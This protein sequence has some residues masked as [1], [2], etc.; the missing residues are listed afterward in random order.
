MRETYIS[1]L[2]SFR[3]KTTKLW[4]FYGSQQ[5]DEIARNENREKDEKGEMAPF[6]VS[7][8]YPFIYVHGNLEASNIASN[9]YE[10]GP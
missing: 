5:K 2:V 6:L 3:A 9:K 8:P 7:N 1:N 4:L 10:S